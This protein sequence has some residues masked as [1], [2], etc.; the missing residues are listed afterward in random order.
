MHKIQ[1]KSWGPVEAVELGYGPVGNPLM[2]VHV[3]WL[4][5]I[6]ID[7]G[8]SHMRSYLLD[9]VTQRAVERVVL[10]HHHEDHAGNAAAVAA[11][12]GAAVH[13]PDGAAR[14]LGSG[15]RILPYQRLIWGP[16]SPI[17]T[18]LP[19]ETVFRTPGGFCLQP[20]PTPGHS[21]DHTSYLETVHGWLFSGDL[22]LG[23]KIKF[24]RSDEVF[25]DQVR[26]LRRVLSLDFD[27]LF[28]AHNPRPGNG[29][30]HIRRKLAF[31][32]DLY[33]RIAEMRKAGLRQRQIVRQV[34]KHSDLFTRLL[35]LGNVSYANMVGSAL[36]SIDA[37]KVP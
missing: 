5:G 20:V 14:K 18:L 29:K 23:E 16:A 24:F 26:S 12:T 36:R 37:G 1:S 15:Y 2:T 35:T 25:I 13:G 32:E 34:K 4:D 22:Y 28:C 10:T 17:Q 31:F 27:T 33:G 19:L 9:W 8:Q 7:S 11:C 30:E 21:Q 3:Y 6:L